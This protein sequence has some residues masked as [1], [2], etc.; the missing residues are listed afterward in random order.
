MGPA[1]ENIE[2]DAGDSRELN[3]TVAAP[4]GT[5]LDGATIRWWVSPQ[6]YGE[7]TGIAFV[8]KSTAAGITITDNDL[9][10]FT[11]QLDEDDTAGLQ[12][13]Y[14][15]EAEVIDSL[16]KRSTVTKGLFNIR[17]SFVPQSE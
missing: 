7:P 12:G 11:V 17:R 9:R 8:K 10:K 13:L 4:E 14:Y 5:T 6:T 3:F 1:I 16:G 2:I 15:H